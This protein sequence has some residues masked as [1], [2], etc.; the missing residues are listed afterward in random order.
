[1]K[2][3]PITARLL[4]LTLLPALLTAGCG[5][6]TQ[7]QAYARAEQA[8]QQFTTETAPALIVEYRR[9]IALAPGSSL[10]QKAEARIR[11]LEARLKAEET[12]KE[13]FQEHG[14]D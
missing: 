8:E 10:A 2:T 6:P 12:H 11:V 3:P 7:A 9:V 13:V 5:D 1:M 14:V 4:S